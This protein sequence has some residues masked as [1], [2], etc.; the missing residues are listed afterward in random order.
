M[1]RVEVV[2]ALPKGGEEPV[3]PSAERGSKSFP[4]GGLDELD[5]PNEPSEFSDEEVDNEYDDDDY[6]S[7]SD[8]VRGLA[9]A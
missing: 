6:Y 3:Q 4:V 1:E 5:L 9:H 2:A 8:Y 7:D